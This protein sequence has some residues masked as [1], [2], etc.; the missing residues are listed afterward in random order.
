LKALEK[1]KYTV[2]R[3]ELTVPARPAATAPAEL[4]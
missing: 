1:D 2:E 4:K 3:P